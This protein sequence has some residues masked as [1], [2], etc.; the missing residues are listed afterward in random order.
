VD[1]RFTKVA[2]GL[3]PLE[4]QLVGSKPHCLVIDNLWAFEAPQ[5]AAAAV[6]AA[7]TA[8]PAGETGDQN[9]IAHILDCALELARKKCLPLVL[10][11]EHKPLS[12]ACLSL[13]FTLVQNVDLSSGSCVL[14]FDLFEWSPE[15]PL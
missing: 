12:A 1:E 5:A 2:W 4:N 8:A 10:V 3:L 14:Q 15:D 7:A 6:A 13:G 9:A 11:S